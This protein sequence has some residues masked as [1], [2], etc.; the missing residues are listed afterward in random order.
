MLQVTYSNTFTLMLQVTY[1][2]TLTLMLQVTLTH[3][4]LRI[5]NSKPNNATK[6]GHSKMNR[7]KGPHSL[8]HTHTT[9]L[10]Y[11]T[12]ALQ[13]DVFMSDSHVIPEVQ[14]ANMRTHNWTRS[15]HRSINF[16]TAFLSQFHSH[17][18]CSMWPFSNRFC[19]PILCNQF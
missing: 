3:L 1:S 6:C 16:I 17:S 5:I 11:F 13:L 12:T 15:Q 4:Y 18:S 8:R 2:N 9:N 19:R 14:K 10:V 7:V